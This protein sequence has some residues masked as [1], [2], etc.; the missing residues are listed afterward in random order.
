M[1][2][3]FSCL[4][5]IFNINTNY[6]EKNSS[7]FC[8]ALFPSDAN[9]DTAYLYGQDGQRSHKY[10]QEA[11]T[12]YFNKM[13]TVHTDNGNSIYGGQSAK[14]IYLGETRIVTKL[15]SGNN[16]AYQEECYKQYYYHSD[17]LGSASLI[18]DYKGD[19]YQRI[20]YTPYGETWV[21]K[22]QNSG[23]EHLPYRFTAK[24]LD[25]ETGLYYYGARYLDPKYSMWISTDPA[26]GEYIPDMG[27]GNAKDSGSLP[28]M[29][30]VYNHINFHLYHYAGNNPVKY[31]DPDGRTTFL[32]VVHADTF[33]EKV[34]GGSHCGLYFSNPSNFD[35]TLYDPSGSFESRTRANP[36][37]GHPSNGIFGADFSDDAAIPDVEAYLGYHLQVDGQVNV[38]VLNTTPQEEEKMIDAAQKLKRPGN[39][40]CASRCS[41]VLK[42]KQFKRTARPGSLEKQ[43]RQKLKPVILK[44]EEDIRNFI[45]DYKLELQDYQKA[46][47]Y[48]NE[49]R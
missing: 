26:L 31:T 4:A 24:E 41:E 44:T 12:L 28:G 23:L 47:T 27:K 25:E 29:G 21:E 48:I 16:P 8:L 9:N 32:F 33:W 15:N 20:E 46:E 49:D 10:T 42:E 6:K 36:I 30:G 39:M 37:K 45:K 19:E 3:S 5:V 11:E 18:S 7:K 17:H 35:K 38:Y 22:S 34:A 2:S 14:N 40:S 13:W 43:A 1:S